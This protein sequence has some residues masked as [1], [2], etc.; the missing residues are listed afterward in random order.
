MPLVRDAKGKQTVVA[1][2]S[3]RTGEVWNRDI[4]IAT[5]LSDLTEE[6]G[7]E[8]VAVE[9]RFD[10]N[11]LFRFDVALPRVLVAIEFQ[12]FYKGGH[13]GAV[14][15]HNDAQKFCLAASLGWILFP[16]PYKMLREEY[17]KIFH[18]VRKAARERLLFAQTSVLTDYKEE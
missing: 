17:G 12:G 4:A 16:V 7:N 9:Y 3:R 1:L 8:A 18:Q 5:F 11:R 10:P 2:A 6:F 15:F 14:G 13:A